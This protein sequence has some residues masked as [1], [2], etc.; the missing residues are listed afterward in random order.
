MHRIQ[1]SFLSKIQQLIPLVRALGKLYEVSTIAPSEVRRHQ[2]DLLGGFPKV[3]V[4]VI[5]CLSRLHFHF[6]CTEFQDF[7]TSEPDPRIGVKG[8]NTEGAWNETNSLP[9][10]RTSL[11]C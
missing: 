3:T 8:A 2:V 5:L 11:T 6:A 10:T 4:T 7:A 1:G 9:V